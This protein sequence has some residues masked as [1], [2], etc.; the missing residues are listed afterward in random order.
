M[1]EGEDL[2][3]EELEG[4]VAEVTEAE[5]PEAGGGEESPSD[6]E[7]APDVVRTASDLEAAKALFQSGV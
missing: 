4:S 1:A 6:E 3:L 5:S 2:Q 7:G